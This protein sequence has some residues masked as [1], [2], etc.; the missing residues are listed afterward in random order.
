VTA[1]TDDGKQIFRDTKIYMPQSPIYGRGNFMWSG[2]YP[3]WKAGM[4]RDTSLQPG[5]TKTET[6]EI[7]FPYE[8]I[9]KQGKKTK[10][11]KAETMDVAIKLWY[12]PAGGDPKEAIPGKTSFLFFETNKTVKLKP[13]DHY[14]K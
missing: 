1:K 10:D 13:R 14:I 8:Q 7:T 4:I 6:F 12:L 9:E 5:Q 11:V 2:G 3:G